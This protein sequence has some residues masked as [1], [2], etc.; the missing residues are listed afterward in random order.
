MLRLQP[1][2]T[3][4]AVAQH[5]SYQGRFTDEHRLGDLLVAWLKWSVISADYTSSL[6]T[7]ATLVPAPKKFMQNLKS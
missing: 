1:S 6:K 5:T 2:S 7:Y 3:H 4:D